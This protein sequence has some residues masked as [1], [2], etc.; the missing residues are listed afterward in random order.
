M[1]IAHNIKKL[2]EIFDLTQ[3]DLAEVAGVTKNAVSQ[4]ENGRAEPR[5]GAIERMAACYGLRKSYLIEDGGMDQVDPVTRKPRKPVYIP[6]GAMRVYSSGEATVPLLT[7]GRV[8]AGALTDEEEAESR[9]EVPASVCARHPRAFALVVEGNC[10]N[11]VIPEG[12]HVLV[13]PDREPHNGSIAV[14][15]TEAYQAVMRRWYRG[16]STLM[17]TADS[18]EE[19]EDMVFGMDDGPVRVIGTVVWWQAPEEME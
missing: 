2:R 4:W 16:S 10:M 11:R 17:L 1:S 15:E 13:D 18:Y 5:M 12:A 7:L 19:Q 9:V 3:A 6:D 14:V 8:H